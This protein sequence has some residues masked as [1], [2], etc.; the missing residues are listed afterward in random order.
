M[1]EKTRSPVSGK[2]V[3][4]NTGSEECAI[5]CAGTGDGTRPAQEDGPVKPNEEMVE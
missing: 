1:Q 3:C 5:Y 4:K 2:N